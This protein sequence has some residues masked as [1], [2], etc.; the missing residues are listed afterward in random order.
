MKAE[1]RS[2]ESCNPEAYLRAHYTEGL[3]GCLLTELNSSHK[4]L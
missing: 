1:G 2:L 4:A 3:G